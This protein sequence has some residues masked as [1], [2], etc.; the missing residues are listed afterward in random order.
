M[1]AA[2]VLPGYFALRARPRPAA[3]AAVGTAA[4]AVALFTGIYAPRLRRLWISPAVAAILRAATG[5]T[6]S[7][8]VVVG[9]G[10]P[11]IVFLL[12]TDTIFLDPAAAARYAAAHPG[13]VV[14][15]AE[16]SEAEFLRQVSRLG[17]PLRPLAT[18]DGV[19]YSKGRQVSLKIFLAPAPAATP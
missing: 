11:S 8:A 3:A 12:G 14:I 18:V 9:H 6:P 16:R 4:V 2:G 7:S 15:V 10:E 1:L 13:C 19:N 5:G 17:E